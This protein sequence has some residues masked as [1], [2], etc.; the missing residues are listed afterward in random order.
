MEEVGRGPGGRGKGRGGEEGLRSIDIKPL[1]DHP[2]TFPNSLFL[3]RTQPHKG[4]PPTHRACVPVCRVCACACVWRT[5]THRLRLRAVRFALRSRQTQAAVDPRPRPLPLALDPLR[6]DPMDPGDRRRLLPRHAPPRLDANKDK[7]STA[8]RETHGERARPMSTPRG[9][10]E[11]RGR[12]SSGRARG[13]SP[14][15]HGLARQ[16][17]AARARPRSPA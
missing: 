6:I 13:L 4:E 16:R 10:A 15:S 5:R 8:A 3:M 2:P 1:L 17:P 11:G 9:T 14:L 7:S 12:C